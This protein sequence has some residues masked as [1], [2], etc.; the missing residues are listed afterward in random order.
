[1]LESEH[2]HQSSFKLLENYSEDL[3][4]LLFFVYYSGCLLILILL[5]I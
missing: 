4:G 1:M 2:F 3:R 5:Y